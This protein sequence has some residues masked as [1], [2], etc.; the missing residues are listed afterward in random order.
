M[1]TFKTVLVGGIA[2]LGLDPHTPKVKQKPGRK[3]GPIQLP[4]LTLRLVHITMATPSKQFPPAKSPAKRTP[5]DEDYSTTYQPVDKGVP[6]EVN[7]AT[8]TAE[9][10]AAPTA[11][12]TP[13]IQVVREALLTM[14]GDLRGMR[15]NVDTKEIARAKAM[16]EVS[17]VLIDTARVENEFL[18]LSGFDAGNSF[19]HASAA[20]RLTAPD[21]Q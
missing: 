19:I 14:L 16:A 18:T 20:P 2:T 9:Q 6:A 11:T 8:G 4:K 5:A 15:G 13:G 12:Q 3:P 17:S 7:H 21:R 10:V 1:N